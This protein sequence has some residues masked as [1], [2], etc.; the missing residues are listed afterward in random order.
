MDPATVKLINSEFVPLVQ[1]AFGRIVTASGKEI[2]RSF[3]GQGAPKGPEAENNPLAPARLKAALEKFS[4]LPPQDRRPSVDELPDQWKKKS[5]QLVEPPAGGLIL[6]QYLRLLNRDEQGQLRGQ[7]PI[8]HD[9]LWMTEAEW[10]SL[11]PTEPSRG[12][13]VSAAWLAKRIG[14]HHADVIGA[15]LVIW[16]A[17]Q[18][19]PSL[20]LTVEEV[21][22]AEIKMRLDG[23][24]R[25]VVEKEPLAVLD[26]QAAGLATYNRKDD[27]F[28]RFQLALWGDFVEDNTRISAYLP[29]GRSLAGGLWFELT[30]GDTPFERLPPGRSGFGG[31]T[32]YFGS[33]DE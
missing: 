23:S 12:A 14:R 30:P 10:K 5:E 21:S 2:G 4:Q 7:G 27:R 1:R 26:Y 32:R 9:F 16:P 20:V 25:V 6:K 22:G 17:K 24:V 18:P 8:S 28:S 29:E 33:A 11:V 3:S 31:L 15:S 13:S 19:E